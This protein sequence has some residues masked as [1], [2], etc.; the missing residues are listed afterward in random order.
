MEYLTQKALEELKKKIEHLKNKRKDIA[1]RI[2][3]AKELGDLSENAEYNSAKEDQAFLESEIR[4]LENLLRT[5]VVVKIDKNNKIVTPGVCVTIEMGKEKKNLCLVN[6][7]S[8][9]P[10]EGKISLHSPLGKA[11]L[12]KKVGESG[13]LQTPSGKKTF[14]VIAVRQEE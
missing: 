8:V 12:N 1:E 11:L 6:P 3:A 9:S 2:N 7:E 14:K 10:A 4:R 13:A 5:A